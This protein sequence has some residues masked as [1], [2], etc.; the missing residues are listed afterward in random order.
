[1]TADTGSNDLRMI[2]C[3]VS[4]GRPG[5]RE[6]LMT[7]ITQVRGINVIC[8]FTTGLNTIMAGNTAIGRQRCMVNRSGYPLLCTMT[9]IALFAG[10]DVS[11]TFTSSNQII[12]TAGTNPDYLIVVY[13]TVGNRCPWCWVHCMAGVAVIG[14]INVIGTFT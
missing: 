2:H 13:G 4:N 6:A 9:H 5:C 14:G 11:R 8:T 12:V 1:M 3:P 7:V 10:G